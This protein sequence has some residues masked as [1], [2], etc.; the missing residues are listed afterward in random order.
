[1][2]VANAVKPKQ[3]DGVKVLVS[4]RCNAIAWSLE[5]SKSDK[6]KRYVR[7]VFVCKKKKQKKKADAGILLDPIHNKAIGCESKGT[8]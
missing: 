5:S 1:M 7:V 8:G 4:D 3:S 6:E 2:Y